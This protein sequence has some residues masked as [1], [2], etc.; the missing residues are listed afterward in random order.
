MS[1]KHCTWIICWI[2]FKFTFKFYL[3]REGNQ[4]NKRYKDLRIRNAEVCDCKQLELWWNDGNVMAHAGFP[5]GLGTTEQ[6]IAAQIADDSDETKR[7]LIIEFQSRPIGEMCFYTEKNQE[8]EIGIK[9]CEMEY[10]EKGLGR[11]VLSMLIDELFK[12]GAKR[13][14]L[15]TNLTNTR[16]QHVYELLGFR[17]TGV[18]ENSWKNQLGELQSSVDYE[19]LK[20]D[21]HT[22]IE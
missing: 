7:R 12:M 19:L 13:I 11:I 15:D 10:Q 17:K 9:I 21:F 3:Q 22:F 18:H 1:E 20:Q 2:C 8:Y 6:K 5:Q 14:Y 4:L 16:A